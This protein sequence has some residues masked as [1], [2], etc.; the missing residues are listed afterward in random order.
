MHLLY[1]TVVK[2]ACN[3]YHLKTTHMAPGIATAADNHAIAAL[4]KAGLRCADPVFSFI[5]VAPNQW[6]VITNVWVD[7]HRVHSAMLSVVVMQVT[8]LEP[9]WAPSRQAVDQRAFLGLQYTPPSSN[10]SANVTTARP[11][12]ADGKFTCTCDPATVVNKGCTCGAM[13]KEL[14]AK[15]KKHC[16]I[17]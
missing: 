11:L 14:E 2:L 5:P 17:S 7:A 15:G 12:M 4:F 3:F 1:G 13:K 6:G 8:V 9:G 16:F 10:T